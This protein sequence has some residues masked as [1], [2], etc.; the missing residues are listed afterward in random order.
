MNIN[1]AAIT[2]LCFGDS[3]TYGTRP[4]DGRFSADVRWTGQLQRMLGDEYYVVEEGLGGR[5]TNLESPEP[6]DKPGRDGLVYF[7]PCLL[8]HA[9]VGVVIIMLGTNDLK[10]IYSRT[11]SE[12]AAVFANYCDFIRSVNKDTHI[13]LVSPSLIKAVEPYVYFDDVFVQKA[14]ALAQEIEKIAKEKN[15]HFYDAAQVT[16]VGEDGLHWDEPSQERFAESLENI[17]RQII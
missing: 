7:R 8:S 4:D 10:N 2:V 13:V 15:V 16:K 12:I 5:T 9:P 6:S 3:N 11:P 17:L 1:P 14:A